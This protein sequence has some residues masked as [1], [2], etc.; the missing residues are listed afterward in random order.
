MQN[1]LKPRDAALE[2]LTNRYQGVS[3][4]GCQFLGQVAG[5][6]DRPLSPKQS[7]WLIKLCDEAGLSVEVSA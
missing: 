7:D 2:I 5:L 1:A 4:K 3:W 6:P